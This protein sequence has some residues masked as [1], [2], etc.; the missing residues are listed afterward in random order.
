[1]VADDGSDSE[2]SED[3]GQLRKIQ[4]QTITEALS[5]IE[6]AKNTFSQVLTA[7]EAEDKYIKVQDHFRKVLGA[8]SI[9][10]LEDAS[11]ILECVQAF[12]LDEN[13]IQQ[14]SSNS[15][16]LDAF[17]DSLTSV[18]CYLEAL[19]V[20]EGN[21]KDILEYW[22]NNASKLVGNGLELSGDAQPLETVEVKEFELE[23][24]SLALQSADNSRSKKKI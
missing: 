10:N 4:V 13:A 9:L 14:L 21:P 5:E 12:L 17:A 20:D 19:I 7:P 23:D 16:L 1:M 24:D 8:L 3:A 11:K 22:V 18:E 15:E 6:E 2:Q